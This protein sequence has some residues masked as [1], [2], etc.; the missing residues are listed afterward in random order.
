MS[1]LRA[2]NACQRIVKCCERK[3]E[4]ARFSKAVGSDPTR[5][6]GAGPA[7]AFNPSEPIARAAKANHQSL[8]LLSGG[9]C[10]NHA[11]S[12]QRAGSNEAYPAE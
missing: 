11:K 12:G 4:V 9:C 5:P 7:I 8:M 6:S 3:I 2:G 10:M 1:V